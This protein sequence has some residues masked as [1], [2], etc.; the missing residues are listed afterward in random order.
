MG[1]RGKLEAQ[2]QARRLRA[3]NM[4]LADIAATLGVSKSSVS[5]WV[6]DVP[7]TPSKRRYGPQRRPHPAHAAKLRQIEE[8]NELAILRIGTLGEQAFLAAGVALYAGEGA[9]TDGMVNF[10]NTDAGMVAFFCAWLRRF[11][12]IDESRLRVTVYLHEGL[13]LDAAERHWSEL[14]G[15]PRRQFRAPYR[16]VADPTIRRTKH[17]FGCVYVRYSCSTTHRSIMGLIRALLSSQALSGVAQL[18]EQRAVNATVD[19]FESLPRSKMPPLPDESI[20]Q[21]LEALPDW[22]RE[23]DEIVKTFELPSFPDAIAFVTRVADLAEK[24]NHHPDLD[25]RYRKVRVALSTHDQGGI[26]D[27]DFALAAQIEATS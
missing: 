25:I 1:Y 20:A 24:A 6:R 13:D 26:T 9:K 15:I 23:A 19:G 10:A 3:E 21:R 16:A 14:T 8:L 5:V 2:E 4:T 12:V 27:K 22:S 17:E 18:A 7:F 11:F